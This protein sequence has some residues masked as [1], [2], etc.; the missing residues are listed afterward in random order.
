ME[1]DASETGVGA[2]LPQC[3]SEKPKLHLVAFFSHKLSPGIKL[4]PKEWRYWLEG[5]AH[6]FMVLTDQKNWSG[7]GLGLIRP[8]V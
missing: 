3:T 6:P 2:I 7:A 8:G 1:V 5:A 4:A